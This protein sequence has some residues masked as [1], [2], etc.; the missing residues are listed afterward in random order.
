M[1]VSLAQ[2]G[3]VRRLT[4]G[5]APRRSLQSAAGGILP[6][7]LSG[8]EHPILK[9]LHFAL[10]GGNTAA[11]NR[12]MRLQSQLAKAGLT[13]ANAG[14]IADSLVYHPYLGPH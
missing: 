9:A 5:A 11:R 10:Y 7:A 4:K 13:S 12:Q 8:M 1:A 3:A 2:K 14:D 6:T